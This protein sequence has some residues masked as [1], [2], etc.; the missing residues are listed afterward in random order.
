MTDPL[1]PQ[2]KI[3]SWERAKDFLTILVIPVF[4]WC[5]KVS[6]NLEVLGEKVGRAE[7]TIEKLDVR[8][9]AQRER[10]PHLL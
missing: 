3:I 6:I 5:G 2:P 7:T 10:S 8:L 9:E 4:L 1:S